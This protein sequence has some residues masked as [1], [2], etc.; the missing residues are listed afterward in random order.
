MARRLGVTV[1][2]E[3]FDLSSSTALTE[4]AEALGYTDAWSYES[5]CF[6]S[7]SPLAAVA[8]RTSSMRLGT[9][10]T[11]AFTRPA[12]LIAMS[13]AA[14]AELAPGRFALG[15][16]SSTEAIVTGWMGLAYERPLSRVCEVV[17]TIRSLLAG[18]KVGAFRL[19]R[20][21]DGQVPIFVAALGDRML[22]LAG[23]M[24]DGVVFFL[25]SAG[26]IPQ[27]M[28]QV[29]RPMES[30]ARV[31]VVTGDD[32]DQSLSWVRRFICGYAVT[33]F[34]ASF[35]VRQG[36]AE[37][38]A[39]INRCWA[40]GDRERAAGQ[41]S[42]TMVHE[43]ALVGCGSDVQERIERYFSTGLGV[44]DLWFKSSSE[45]PA[46]RRAEIRRALLELAPG[47]R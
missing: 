14:I 10:I 4:R 8:M 39:A 12:P 16:G 30:V 3:A 35:L 11:S 33:P 45:D 47:S 26:I 28:A 36:F 2:V 22:Q 32:R 34:Y 18:D 13:A 25:A 1:P 44:L 42:D 7:F 43:L 40:D 17:Q 23:Q 6:D 29:G 19:S 5:N 15:I 27:L 9:S 21:P 46:M 38:V 41:V 24:A 20:P 31:V 37:E